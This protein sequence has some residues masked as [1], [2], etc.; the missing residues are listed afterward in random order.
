MFLSLINGASSS[1]HRWKEQFLFISGLAIKGWKMQS[2]DWPMGFV[3][4]EIP[5]LGKE[6]IERF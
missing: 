3:M 1:V 6:E 2:W 5:I 4:R